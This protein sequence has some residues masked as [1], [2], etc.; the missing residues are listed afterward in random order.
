MVGVFRDRRRQARAE[1]GDRRA[2]ARTRVLLN[3]KIVYGN[4]YTADCSIRDLT[5]AGAK[6]ALSPNEAAPSD[7]YL[8]VIRNGVAHRSRTLWRREAE[9]GVAFDHSYDFSQPTPPELKPVREL[10]AHLAPH[11]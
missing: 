2:N 9:A 4:G 11:Q 7:F 3:G 6:L 5:V 10:W 8:I 1:C